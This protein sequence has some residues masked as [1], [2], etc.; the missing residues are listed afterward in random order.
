MQG[1]FFLLMT[2]LAGGTTE[3]VTTQVTVSCSYPVTH[4][5]WSAPNS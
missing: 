1:I 5:N 3:E 4:L 2:S